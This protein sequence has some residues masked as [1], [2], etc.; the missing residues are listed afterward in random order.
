MFFMGG[1]MFVIM[2]EKLKT[3]K[4]LLQSGRNYQRGS[5]T[6]GTISFQLPGL[7]EVAC[8]L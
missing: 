8:V 1:G 7:K 4:A 6:S 3:T 2:F 5:E